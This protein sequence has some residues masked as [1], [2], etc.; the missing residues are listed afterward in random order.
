MTPLI[1]DKGLSTIIGT[2]NRDSYGKPIPHRNRRTLYRM[3]KLDSRAKTR[4]QDR[5]HINAM[6]ELGRI[7]TILGVPQNVRE[8]TAVLYHDA[9][10]KKL[11]R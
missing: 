1:H 3:R 10:K 5:N 11:T 7:A 4:P 9:V 8:R 6:I 2:K